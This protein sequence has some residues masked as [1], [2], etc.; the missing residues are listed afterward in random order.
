MEQMKSTS[1]NGSTTP[2]SQITEE[3]LRGMMQDE[4][5]WNPARRDMDYVKQV[6]DGWQK[7]ARA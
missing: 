1:V 6:D 5:Y 3:S 4:R 2:A 7:F